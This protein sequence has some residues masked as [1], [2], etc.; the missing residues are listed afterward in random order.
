MTLGHFPQS[1][2]LSTAGGWVVTRSSGQ[3][4]LRYGRIEQ[5]FHA[6]PAGDAARRARGRRPA[7]VERRAR[8]A[9]G[10]ARQRRPSRPAHRGD[11]AHPAARRAR[12]LSTRIFFPHWDAGLAA[13][14]AAGAGRRGAVDAALC[15]RGRD[16][17]PAGDGRRPRRRARLAEALPALARRRRRRVHAA[18]RRHRQRARGAAGALGARR[19]RGREPRRRRRHGDRQGLGEEPLPRPV[20]AQQPLGRRHRASRRWRP[21]CG[22]TAATAMLRGDR[23]RRP[24][25]AGRRRRAGPRL[26]PPLARLSAG[27]QRLLDLR[28]SPRRRSRRQP[29]ALAPA[30]DGGVA[31]RWSRAA[32]RSATST[33]SASTTR[34]I[35]R[36]KRASSAWR[37]C[38][39][40][41]ASS[42]PG[43]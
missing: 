11:A 38:A 23:R 29:R 9:R 14:R 33:A 3:Q 41:R 13:V 35:S 16:R 24:G 27:L 7:G 40:R 1:F 12:A 30:Q 4:S 31:R 15:E 8:P 21:A 28:L 20:P 2:E 39:P 17:H 6:R 34:R 19:D 32:A 5:L 10:G 42:T 26:H 25:G 18:R 43:R 22:W 36:R 37:C